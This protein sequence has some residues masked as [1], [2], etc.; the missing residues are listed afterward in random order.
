MNNPNVY[1]DIDDYEERKL[2]HLYDEIKHKEVPPPGKFLN[3]NWLV[4]S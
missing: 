2:D 1:Q 3:F 4:R